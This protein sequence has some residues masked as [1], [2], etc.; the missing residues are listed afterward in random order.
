MRKFFC[1]LISILMLSSALAALAEENLL[2][3]GDFS[4]T[5]GFNPSG[6]SREM[7]FT[8][9]G[10]SALSIETDGYEGSCISVSNFGLNDA[11]F[12]QTV[13]V[14]PDTLYRISC[15]CR[16]EGIGD[17]GIGATIS[18]KDTFCYS[19]E[20]TDTDGEWLPLELYGRTGP[21]QAELTVFARVGGYSNEN[22]GAAWFDNF[23]MIRLDA[24]PDD[25]IVWDF[26][27]ATQKS[28]DGFA[29][30]EADEIV[31]ER[32]TEM[33]VL[34]TCIY[35]L[36]VL[37]VARKHRRSPER[38]AR[39]Y[40]RCFAGMLAGALALRLVLA[41]RIPGYN[42]DINCFTSWSLHMTRVGPLNFYNS[43]VWCDYPPLYMW[44]LAPI[45]LIQSLFGLDLRSGAQ[46]V[47][48]KLWPILFDLAA[49]WLI[50]NRAKP[51]LG[52]RAALLMSVFF[53][54]NPAVFTDS[55]AWGQIDSVFTLLVAV[56][57]LEASDERYLPSLACFAL[58]VLVKPQAL[59]FA[60]LGLFA[61]IAD[62]VRTRRNPIRALI[63]MAA[64]LGILYLV[65]LVSCARTIDLSEGL[66]SALIAPVQW[67]S[68]LYSGTMQGYE[69]VTINALNL[70]YLFGLNWA[71][72]AAHPNVTLFA[73]ICFALSYVYCMAL[74][75]VSKNRRHLPLLGGTLIVLI[76]TFGPMIHERYIYPAI[77]L[78]ALGYLYARDKRILIS[79][80]VLSA[81]LFLNEVLVLQGGMT[82]A[83]YGHLQ[84]SEDWLN[85]MVSALNVLNAL[86]L[87]W[88]ALDVCALGH[89][90][91]LVG[92]A[93]E[94]EAPGMREL[95]GKRDYRLRLN[96]TDA[97]LMA[98]VTL[99]YAA[100]AFTNL[101]AT[102]APQTT[103]TSGAAGEQA[104]F[105]LGE[106]RRFRMTYYGN[107]CN[108]NFT[109]ELSNDGESWTEPYCAKYNQGEIF[110]WLW[111]VP[112]ES[113]GETTVYD[114]TTPTDDGSA[115]V[116]FAG[117]EGESY[118]FQTARYVRITAAAPGLK[119]SEVGFLDEDGHPY[120]IASVE[121]FGDFAVS[122][123]SLLADEQD[124]IPDHPSYYNSTYFDEIYHART[125]YEHLHGLSTYEWTHPPLGKV[126]MM[127][128]I[129]I[130]G[131]TPFG[132]RF[133]G[134]LVG[135]L[136][137]PLMYLLVKQLTKSTK[138]S[139]IAMFLLSVDAMHFTQTRIATI[140]SYSVFW[141]MLM[142]LFMFRFCQMPWHSVKE[143]NKSLVPLG[144]CGVTMGVAWA[145][146]WIGLYASAGL[147]VLFF[148][149]LYR[150][151]REYRC[152]RACTAKN[153]SDSA[154][155]EAVCKT[156]WT[157]AVCS[158]AFCLI[159]FVAIPVLIYYFSYYWHLQSEGV[160]WIG[161]MFSLQRVQSVID[162]QKRMFNYHAGL[163]G[164]T[165]YFRSPWYQWPIIWWPMWYYSGTPYMPAGVISSISC[166][167]NP[168]VWWFGL[169]ALIFVIVRMC[170]ARR[171]PRS[172]AMVVI[173]F[174]SQFLPWVIVPRSTFIY[175]YFAS[176]PF[177]IIASVL[178]LK[179]IRSKSVL[180]FRITAATLLIAA[181][182]LFI[183]FYPL[184]SGL[185][186]ARWYANY[187]RWFRW[188]NF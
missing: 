5:D 20:L 162:L 41:A 111:Y 37:A 144:L 186:V 80:T 7:W 19:D 187:L 18:V 180:V 61:I 89:A 167:G 105:D 23:E 98:A 113:D 54:F 142:Y 160:S 117:Y 153:A 88:T 165:H 188:Y 136:M 6:W 60:P 157:N 45:G 36:A 183:A 155:C 141:I 112:L 87:G 182:L 158:I 75:A 100:A 65:G 71:E 57:A 107:I 38:D 130:F 53:A 68:S 1:V 121:Q 164:D 84:A 73:W 159:F 22:T 34:L 96:C 67:L 14:E 35:M 150:R 33:Y 90:Y 145:T 12:A 63:G 178:M 161:D 25:A 86:F 101:G 120:P 27:P 116:A 115:Y 108:S 102:K 79:L 118:P 76:C 172:Y 173:G 170:L 48:L 10:V 2:V 134:A 58:A 28:S 55:A 156:F 143:F 139:F 94:S 11:R 128:G 138:L 15:L 56:C 83:N 179:W 21:E 125:A 39:F 95:F 154:L 114:A 3:N 151:W 8:D 59:L 42:T 26:T 32:N 132:W 131:M 166:M 78:L 177:I 91:P 30:A 110:R 124:T 29:D 49:A 43:G 52:A 126:L 62:H 140:D 184:E 137:L 70:Y 129:Q 77:L 13:S 181:L 122:D 123:A 31:P 81:T 171:A 24:A 175:H 148:W 69:R 174:A 99:V 85:G 50:W 119:L 163:G 168:A 147:A 169:I 106:T 97:L 64:A 104:V 44:M 127:V 4:E 133:M 46:L 82:A 135:V 109:V 149:S 92:C 146:K 40:G 93:E 9:E 47:V 176:V 72:T 17:S 103:W 185:P 152:A 74:C 51:K 16:A 66:L